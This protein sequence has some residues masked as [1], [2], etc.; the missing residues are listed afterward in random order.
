[1]SVFF[2]TQVDSLQHGHTTP[3]PASRKKTS[4]LDHDF[5]GIP[6][7]P[8]G[9]SLNAPPSSGPQSLRLHRVIIWGL[10]TIGFQ[11]DRAGMRPGLFNNCVLLRIYR[12]YDQ[13]IYIWFLYCCLADCLAS[14]GAAGR[15]PRLKPERI[16]FSKYNMSSRSVNGI[17]D[18]VG[19]TSLVIKRR[20]N[21]IVGA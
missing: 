4:I 19:W 12:V 16:F 14:A 10:N 2:Q 11:C 6:P 18:Y 13:S 5:H 21:G 3:A 7:D 8:S 1:M 17:V 9:G 15:P 20:V